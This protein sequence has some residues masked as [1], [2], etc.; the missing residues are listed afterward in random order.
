MVEASDKPNHPTGM[1]LQS[2]ACPHGASY[3]AGHLVGQALTKQP[4]RSQGINCHAQYIHSFE[5]DTKSSI[6]VPFLST[7]RDVSKT[8]W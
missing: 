4:R 8:N 3:G 1:S 6:S 7:R 5:G 2:G